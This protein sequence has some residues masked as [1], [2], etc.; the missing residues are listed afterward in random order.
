MNELVSVI[1][2]VYNME[3]SLENCVK[4][5]Q[6]QTYQNIEIILVDDGSK[7][8]TISVCRKIEKSDSRVTC[9][10]T[11]NRGSGPARN[12]GIEA[13]KG[14]YLYFPDA[15]DYLEPQ[16]IEK[17]VA[18]TNNGAFD[19]VVFGY[20]N[21][22]RNNELIS[23]RTYDEQTF[24]GEE[25]RSDFSD[26]LM[27]DRKWSV[28]GAPWNKF[29]SGRIVR[30]YG[31]R[32]P[33]LRRQQDE[34]F[35]A[36]YMCHCENAHYITDVLYTYYPNTVSMEW[37]KFPVN[38][39]DCVKGIHAIFMETIATWS[40][41][42]TVINMLLERHLSGVIKALE[43]SY[44]PKMGFTYFSRRK[45][46]KEQIKNTEL[47]RFDFERAGSI[48]Q[49]LLLLA[50]KLNCYDILALLLY[51]GMRKRKMQKGK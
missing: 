1:I 4:S 21:C 36:R 9:I 15:D 42:E 14:T 13:S 8:G 20:R 12:T 17:L 41:N 18:A 11:E 47:K 24:A 19:L 22:K 31:I 27:M 44:S 3:E 30:E 49:K 2:P 38:Y 33:A 23:E 26:F 37:D 43:L 35:I 39:I 29:F 28:Q 6:N 7:D 46:L 16:A 34:G 10:H 25:I 5:I 32:Y 45:W 51:V 48:Y 40:D 50:V